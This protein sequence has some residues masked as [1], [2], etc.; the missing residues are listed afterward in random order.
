[1]SEI[2]AFADEF[3]VSYDKTQKGKYRL[4]FQNSLYLCE[5]KVKEQQYWRCITTVYGAR[6]ILSGRVPR[7][8]KPHIIDCMSAVQ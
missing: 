7:V 6:L 3:G 8:T 2:Y 5:K 1:M 4:C